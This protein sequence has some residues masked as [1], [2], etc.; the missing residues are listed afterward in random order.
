MNGICMKEE[1][2]IWFVLRENGSGT[3]QNKLH[4]ASRLKGT[5]GIK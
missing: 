5:A 1:R 3:L 4:S 2:L